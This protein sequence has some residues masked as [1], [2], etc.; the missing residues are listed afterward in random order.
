MFLDV[1]GH[2]P[3]ESRVNLLQPA[4]R[5]LGQFEHRLVSKLPTFKLGDLPRALIAVELSCFASKIEVLLLHLEDLALKLKS[6]RLEVHHDVKEG[7]RVVQ[8]GRDHSLLGR[9]RGRDFHPIS[10]RRRRRVLTRRHPGLQYF[11]SNNPSQTPR[12]GPQ[13]RRLCDC[14]R[15]NPCGEQ[16]GECDW[17]QFRI[18]PSGSSGKTRPRARPQ[19]HPRSSR[20]RHFDPL[21][22]HLP[23]RARK[24]QVRRLRMRASLA[25]SSR[26]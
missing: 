9:A 3:H 19:Y 16:R 1:I 12:L 26:Q 21:R 14:S 22:C 4:K 2:L 18:N 13:P 5:F 6:L 24:R 20:P 15:K 11:T 7:H 8:V 17:T 23:T 10:P 25:R